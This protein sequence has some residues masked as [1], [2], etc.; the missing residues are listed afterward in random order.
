MI[1]LHFRIFLKFLKGVSSF[2]WE[3]RNEECNQG[4]LLELNLFVP[5][6]FR[7]SVEIQ[8]ENNFI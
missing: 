8:V 4:T 7:T 6:S 1:Y 5:A 2:Y 3:F